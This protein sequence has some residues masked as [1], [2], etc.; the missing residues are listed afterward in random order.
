[1]ALAS[2][3]F[4]DVLDRLVDRQRDACPGDRRPIP[5][6]RSASAAHPPSP[7]SRPV[8]PRICLS[9]EYSIPADSLFV[10]IHISENR[11]R[12]L[13]LRIY[14]PVFLLKKYAA[15]IQFADSLH[16]FRKKA[17]SPDALACEPRE[18]SSPGRRRKTLK[19]GR[20]AGARPCPHR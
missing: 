2:F 17:F 13:P 19:N 15:Q 5:C 3:F 20:Q 14:P 12:E 8:L 6:G 7:S 11:S 10:H 18:S 1:M 4:R 16:D 9:S